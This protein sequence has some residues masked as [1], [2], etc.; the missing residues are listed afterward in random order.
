LL[1]ILL[2]LDSIDRGAR[3][4]PFKAAVDF[5]LGPYE[6]GVLVIVV[7]GPPEPPF[8]E[9]L[10]EQTVVAPPHIG[11]VFHFD[12]HISDVLAQTQRMVAP[13]CEVHLEQEVPVRRH[14]LVVYCDLAVFARWGEQ[15]L[16]TG[17]RVRVR[18]YRFLAGLAIVQCGLWL[19]RLRLLQHLLHQLLLFFG[20]GLKQI[21]GGVRQLLL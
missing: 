12:F 7:D 3:F 6:I 5:E 19:W 17:Q 4:L 18:I 9:A 10:N 2:L 11:V 16:R 21:A 20:L 14:A 8:E 1:D 13:V 15:Q